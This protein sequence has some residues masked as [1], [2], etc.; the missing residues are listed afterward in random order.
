MERRKKFLYGWK[1]EYL[2]SNLKIIA[3]RLDQEKAWKVVRTGSRCAGECRFTM[4]R[5]LMPRAH[6]SVREADGCGLNAGT[7]RMPIKNG[8]P[9]KKS[10]NERARILRVFEKTL[11]PPTLAG[12]S[13][14]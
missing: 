9:E 11:L 8:K 12:I 10:A 3:F 6:G 2:Y 13:Q 5:A 7:N 1:E 14:R 4:G